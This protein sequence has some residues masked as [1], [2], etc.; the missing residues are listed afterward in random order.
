VSD[1]KT[2]ATTVTVP[3]GASVSVA[4]IW[5]T[6]IDDLKEK[7]D[8]PQN[9]LPWAEINVDK[10]DA[11]KPK[12]DGRVYHVDVH[13]RDLK[14]GEKATADE[15]IADMLTPPTFDP[16]QTDEDHA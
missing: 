9:C 16:D 4:Q 12:K 10:T 15:V 13:Y 3:K 5:G 8:V 11:E 6:A 2:L 14:P 7:G 1:V